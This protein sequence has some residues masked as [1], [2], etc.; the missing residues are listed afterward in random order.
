MHKAVTISLILALAATS[1]AQQMPALSKRE[2]AVKLKA[3]HLAPGAPISIVRSH[4]QEEFGTFISNNR[5]G[6]TFHDMDQ[7]VDVTLR[8]A[9]VRKIKDGYGGYN[10]IK[11]RHTDHTKALIVIAVVAVALGA[12]IG[13]AV[14]AKN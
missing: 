1:G 13:A 3:D 9:D 10:S 4:A 5:D 7:K 11:G 14:A 6:L 2:A 8:Y 12:L